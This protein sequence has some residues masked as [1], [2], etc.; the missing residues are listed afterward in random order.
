MKK[1]LI[2]PGIGKTA[3][4]AIQR[5]AFTHLMDIGSLRYSPFGLIGE[6]HNALADSHP[7]YSQGR[8]DSEVTALHAM[9][10]EDSTQNVL[11]STEFFVN[12]SPET[13]SRIINPLMEKGIHVAVILIVRSYPSLI[14]SAYLQALKTGYGLTYGESLLEYAKRNLEMF[15]VGYQLSRW[16]NI[17]PSS[18]T[19]LE[20][21]HCKSTILETFFRLCGFSGV[22]DGGSTLVN[23][24]LLPEFISIVRNFDKYHKCNNSKRQALLRS[25]MELS[26]EYRE[27]SYNG[28]LISLA[29]NMYGKL[30]EDDI[31][32]AKLNFNKVE[33]V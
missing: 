11:I 1:L 25:L 24:S 28:D 3:T 12:S 20:Y 6:C 29:Q 7:Q 13:I 17:N 2:H 15:R 22:I 23:V 31:R 5:Y 16:D 26:K 9:F 18:I 8:Y 14:V 10:A 30:Y 33:Y 21:D 4:S 19:L 32:L 27:V